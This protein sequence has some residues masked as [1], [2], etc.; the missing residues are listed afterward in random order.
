M[1]AGDGDRI[2]LIETASGTVRRR[3]NHDEGVSAPVLT[4]S[5]VHVGTHDDGLLALDT[6]RPAEPDN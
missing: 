2:C 1:A 4:G 3:L 6:A 5:T